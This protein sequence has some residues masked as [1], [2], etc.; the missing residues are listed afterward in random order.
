MDA[1][2]GCRAVPAEDI[3]AVSGFRG[4][5]AKDEDFPVGAVDS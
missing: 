1:F 5:G 4:G 3:V 2:S